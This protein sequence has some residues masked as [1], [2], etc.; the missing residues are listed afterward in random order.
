MMSPDEFDTDELNELKAAINGTEY[1]KFQSANTVYDVPKQFKDWA[2]ENAGRSQGWKSQPYFIRD[3]FKGGNISGGIKIEPVKPTNIPKPVAA[4]KPPIATPTSAPIVKDVVKTLDQIIA[5]EE[6]IRKNKSFETAVLFDENGIELIRKKGGKRSVRF[7]TD[8]LNQFADK[9]LTHN[10]PGGWQYD[11]GSIM[12]VGNSFSPADVFLAVNHNLAE[13]RAVTPMYTFILRRPKA[14]WGIRQQELT[15]GINETA[16]E[17]HDYLQGVY[18]Q[19][20]WPHNRTVGARASAAHYHLIWK[21]LAKKY[22]L[23]YIKVKSSK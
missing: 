14:G 17:V 22:N 3:N 15:K 20:A 8:E 5:V 2:A 10:H 9:I 21:R 11:K 12:H 18:D 13:V 19:A 4:I 1:E 23:E 16:R 7:S 6:K